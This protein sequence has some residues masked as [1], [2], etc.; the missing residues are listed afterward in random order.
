MT[1]LSLPLPPVMV[2]L[3]VS[4]LEEFCERSGESFRMSATAVAMVTPPLPEAML[5]CALDPLLSKVKL[6]GA[7][8]LMTYAP[9]PLGLPMLR[10]PMVWLV[11]LSDTVLLAAVLATVMVAVLPAPEAAVL[12]LQLPPVAQEEVVLVSFVHVPLLWA[13]AVP[14]DRPSQAMTPRRYFP[15]KDQRKERWGFGTSICIL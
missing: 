3:K 14:K 13:T 9:V 10:M 1:L 4:R 8:P 12:L 11:V 6:T 15:R 2:E 5:I 7:V